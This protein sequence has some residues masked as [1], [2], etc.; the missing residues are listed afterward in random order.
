[1]HITRALAPAAALAL[2]AVLVTAAAPAMAKDG[3]ITT[4]GGCGSGTVWKMKA[5]PDDGRIEVEAEI[6]SNRS[7]QVWAWTL[8]HNGA[9]ALRG[10]GTTR[11]ASGSFEVERKLG[12]FAGQDT[13]AFTAKRNGTTQVCRAL[14]RF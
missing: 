7:G 1:M 8:T 11:G 12:N 14:V 4:S 10:T 3:R 13:F 2:S 6:D 5:S 9:G